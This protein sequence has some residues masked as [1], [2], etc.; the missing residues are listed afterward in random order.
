MSRPFPDPSGPSAS[1]AGPA[2]G[3]RRRGRLGWLVVLLLIV[4]PLAE[5]YVLIQVGQVIGPW[6]TILLLI[7]DSII[8]GWL[9]RRE[10]ARAWKALNAAIGS[11]RMPAR[12]LADG[13]L[14]LIGGTLMLSPGFVTDALGI[15]LILP[16]TRPIF[17]GMLTGFVTRRVVMTA[18]GGAMRGPGRPGGAGGPGDG[19]IVRG[20]VIED[21]PR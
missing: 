2:S 14:I 4:V 5:I 6:W 16:V 7:I 8:G 1:A 10:G 9:I 18:T 20:D 17:R 19:P 3:R 12:E 11:G 13:A 21:P 15:L